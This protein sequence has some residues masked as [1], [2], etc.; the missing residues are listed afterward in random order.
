MPM[1]QRYDRSAPVE[2]V[3]IKRLSR[4]HVRPQHIVGAVAIGCI[5]ILVVK[6]CLH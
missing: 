5:L 3:L 6:L 2:P 4:F 1:N